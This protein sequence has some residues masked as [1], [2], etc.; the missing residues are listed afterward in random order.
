MFARLT[1][2]CAIIPTTL[3]LTVSFFVLFI[4]RK[5]E[6]NILKAFGYVVAS[7]LWLSALLVFSCGVYTLA[8]GKCP[9]QKMMEEKRGMM[10]QKMM[11]KQMMKDK[12]PE[13]KH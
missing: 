6:S 5:V 3:L 8:T 12:M 9:M 1:G 13:M 11:D 2:L 7:L 4:L 10:C